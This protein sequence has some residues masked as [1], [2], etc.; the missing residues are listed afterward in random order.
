MISDAPFPSIV[1]LLCNIPLSDG[2][3]IRF[4]AANFPKI[5]DVVSSLERIGE[6]HKATA[7]QVT[8]AWVLA[9]GPDFVVIP[10]TKKIKVG[11][12][13]FVQSNLSLMTALVP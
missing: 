12:F 8:L 4:S 2:R 1:F 9:Q 3:T 5:L 10:G 13:F 7:G 11:F 6:K